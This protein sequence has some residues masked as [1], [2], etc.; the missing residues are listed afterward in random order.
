MAMLEWRSST[1]LPDPFEAAVGD[2]TLYQVHFTKSLA[3][4][5][6]DLRSELAQVMEKAASFA[7]ENRRD[8]KLRLLFLWDG[9][10]AAMT[11]I[12]TDEHNECDG[13]NVTKCQFTEIDKE[14]NAI[15]CNEPQWHEL[16]R[17]FTQRVRVIVE[18][19][20][21]NGVLDNLP[22]EIDAYFSDQDRSSYGAR[23][24]VIHL[25]V[26]PPK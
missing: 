26:R 7:N 15:S 16:Q 1:P 17:R 25:L 11:V 6:S 9:V 5:D 12:Y 23:N 10:Y 4:K 24:I 22:R 2:F 21:L 19:H 18:E 20:A 3:S 8:T 14:L 13:R